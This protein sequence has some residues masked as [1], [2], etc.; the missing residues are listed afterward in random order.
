M[1]SGFSAA[2]PAPETNEG[3]KKKMTASAAMNF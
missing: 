3:I 1:T 2:L